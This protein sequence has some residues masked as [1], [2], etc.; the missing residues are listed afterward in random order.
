[1]VDFR[2]VYMHSRMQLVVLQ[3]RIRPTI[4]ANQWEMVSAVASEAPRPEATVKPRFFI[5]MI[6]ALPM[7]I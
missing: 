4:R 7:L 3:K 1:M 2:E 5:M 6:A